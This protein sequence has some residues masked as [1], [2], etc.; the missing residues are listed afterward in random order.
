MKRLS[1]TQRLPIVAAFAVGPAIGGLLWLLWSHVVLNLAP[2][3]EIRRQILAVVLIPEV[4]WIAAFFVL[5]IRKQA[6]FWQSRPRIVLL[7]AFVGVMFSVFSLV[8]YLSIYAALY[9]LGRYLGGA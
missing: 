7:V 2:M 4:C 5:T 9:R 3:Q 8:D 6:E 1:T